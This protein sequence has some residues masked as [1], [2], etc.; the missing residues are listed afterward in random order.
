MKIAVDRLT[1]FVYYVY[2]FSR[3]QRFS[4]SKGSIRG[5]TLDNADDVR[6]DARPSMLLLQP[7]ADCAIQSGAERQ[8]HD[9][10]LRPDPRV[11]ETGDSTWHQE[12]KL[13][14]KP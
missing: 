5:A 12:R 10:P 7:A 14:T 1:A 9:L 2:R 6:R 3:H 4:V 8:P 11:M 13:E